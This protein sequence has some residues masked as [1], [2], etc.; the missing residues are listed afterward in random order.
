MLIYDILEHILHKFQIG[1]VDK[2][3]CQT[4][5]REVRDNEQ[6]RI[7]LIGIS[8]YVRPRLARWKY[9]VRETTY[10]DD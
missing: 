4:F 6:Y 1:I 9:D 7:W 10:M 3:Q 5:H 2:Y 8:L